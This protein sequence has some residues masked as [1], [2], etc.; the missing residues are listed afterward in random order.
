MKKVKNLEESLLALQE[1]A[2]RE[3]SLSVQD[4]LKVLSGKG[5]ALVLILLSLPFCLPFQIPGS[6]LPFGLIIA[7]IGLRMAFAKQ[8]WLPKKIQ[9]KNIS[10]RRVRKI[11]KKA[12]ALVKKIKPWIHPRLSWMCSPRAAKVIHGVIIFILGL[13]LALP[14]PVPLSN[15]TAA[16]SILLIS[17]GI[18]EDDGLIVG[19]GY[20]A[21]LATAAIFVLLATAITWA[22]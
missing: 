21:T 13:F 7:F 20:L 8:I 9:L 5:K 12:L 16:W 11:V 10:I 3:K 18:L 6:A 15:I 1:M 22:F 19:L 4:I 17:L 2:E 14:L